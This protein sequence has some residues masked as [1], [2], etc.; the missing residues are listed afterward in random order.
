MTDLEVRLAR[1]PLRV[2]SV[3]S[4]GSPDRLGRRILQRRR[5]LFA[6]DAVAISG[7][8]AL[9]LLF[10]GPH[11]LRAP[12][13]VATA[14]MMAAG[15]VTAFAD[16]SVA[17]SSSHGTEIQIEQDTPNW[18]VAK[19]NGGA[20]FHVVP[21]HERTFEVR[22]GDVRV[23]VLGTTFSVQQLPSGQT[24]VLVEHGSV[25]VAWLGGSTLL[26]TGQGG[27]FPPARSEGDPELPGDTT[28]SSPSPIARG[29]GSTLHAPARGGWREDAHA[30]DYGK[31]YEEL[32][33]NARARDP[34]RDEASDL[35]LAADV[36]RLS[37][38]PEEAV[39]PLRAVC[40]RHAGDRRAPVAAF[41]LGR[42]LLDDLGR[43]AEAAAAFKKA[44]ALWQEG[45]LAEDALAR[46][47][48]AWE[49]A[50]R[51]D[52]ARAAATEYVGRYPQGRHAVT[53]RNILAR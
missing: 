14:G 10:S 48:D 37:A 8:L 20:R 32:S 28:A 29:A 39:K 30:G 52:A 17:E 19:L 3:W 53:M 2:R 15:A 12:A 16:G 23:R 9:V 51:A 26:E 5:S 22:A 24:Q 13:S 38:H 25:E 49:R 1:G 11:A 47:A 31:A 40:D 43:P 50:G 27:T 45:P 33:A 46:E 36:A 34:V 4:A 41:T 35:M 7:C 42:V 21:N 6:L 18:V 44:H